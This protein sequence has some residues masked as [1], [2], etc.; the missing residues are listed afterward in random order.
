MCVSVCENV[1]L[2]TVTLMCIVFTV[3]ENADSVCLL[4]SGSC[5]QY[6]LQSFEYYLVVH[7]IQSADILVGCH[8]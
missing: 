1:E 4:F 2:E 7:S 3:S 5:V 6:V 8:S